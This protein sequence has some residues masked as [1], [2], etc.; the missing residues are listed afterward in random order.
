MHPPIDL[1]EQLLSIF[2]PGE[3]VKIPNKRSEMVALRENLRRT[4]KGTPNDFKYIDSLL[5][6]ESEGKAEFEPEAS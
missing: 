6:A 4:G 3:K 1:F 2:S 5:D